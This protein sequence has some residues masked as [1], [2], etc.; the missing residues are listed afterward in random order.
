MVGRTARQFYLSLHSTPWPFRIHYLIVQIQLYY[1]DLYSNQH[2]HISLEINN[3]L[4]EE[5]PHPQLNNEHVKLLEQD[6]TLQE[7]TD[8]LK[9]TKNGSTPGFSWFLCFYK[10]FWRYL[11]RSILNAMYSFIINKLPSSQD[12]QTI[13][14]ISLI[15]KGEKPKQFLE[16]W[17]PITLQ[18]S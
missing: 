3:F 15:P 11:G 8:A 14:I 18:N 5:Y 1:K 4:N 17:R 10:W 7:L 6:I 2:E 12:S 13:G 16:N 9:K